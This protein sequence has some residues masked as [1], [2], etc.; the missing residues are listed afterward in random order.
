MARLMPADRVIVRE[1]A[2]V[3]LYAEVYDLPDERG[4][5]RYDV[6]YAFDPLGQERRVTLSFPRVQAARPVV[7]ERLTVQPGLVPP[8]RYRVT[9]L[10]RDRILGLT[11]RAVA[12]DVDLR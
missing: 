11:A 2:P 1:G 10:V 8:G 12:L 5:A 9:L 4:M 7:I 3:T 6:T